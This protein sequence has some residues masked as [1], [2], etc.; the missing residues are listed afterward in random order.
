MKAHTAELAEHTNTC[1]LETST[2]RCF[3]S[4]TFLLFQEGPRGQEG[5]VARETNLKKNGL[6]STSDAKWLRS[7]HLLVDVLTRLQGFLPLDDLSNTFDE[8][9]AELHLGHAQAI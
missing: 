5:K 1:H 9:V 7:G 2:P 6:A 8:E 4:S 3:G